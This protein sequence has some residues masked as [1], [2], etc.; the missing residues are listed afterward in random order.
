MTPQDKMVSAQHALAEQAWDVVRCQDA[1]KEAEVQLAKCR[2]NLS[3]A[4]ERR[5]F[6]QGAASDAHDAWRLSIIE[7][8]R[9]THTSASKQEPT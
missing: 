1:V 6:L 9:I 8:H 7:E 3:A 5:D 4:H 2:E